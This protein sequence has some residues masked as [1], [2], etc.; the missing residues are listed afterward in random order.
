MSIAG[1]P[2]TNPLARYFTC[3]CQHAQPFFPP[4]LT[5]LVHTSL[6]PGPLA[7]QVYDNSSRVELLRALQ[8]L[9]ADLRCELGARMQWAPKETDVRLFTG[10]TSLCRVTAVRDCFDVTGSMSSFNISISASVPVYAS[11]QW[12]LGARSRTLTVALASGTVNRLAELERDPH[13]FNGRAGIA[14]SLRRHLS[15]AVLACHRACARG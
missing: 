15:M 13:A 5:H 8:E 2:R 14:W 10:I 4:S 1:L 3:S 7:L 9:P 6:G 11:P 12:Q